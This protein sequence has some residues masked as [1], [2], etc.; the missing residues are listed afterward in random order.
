MISQGSLW[1][2][3]TPGKIAFG[4]CLIHYLLFL[5]PSLSAQSTLAQNSDFKLIRIDRDSSARRLA[6]EYLGDKYEGWQVA[7]LNGR[8]AFQAGDIVAVPLKPINPAAVYAHEYRGV[9][10]LCYH[11]F[12]SGS[13]TKHQME[14]SATE[15]DKQMAYL[16]NNG[17]QVI[18][19]RKMQG[20]LAGKTSI[21][22]KT[23][24]L[25][26]DDGYRSVYEVAYPILKKYDLTA[27]LFVY[28]D[29]IGGSMALS[30]QQ[31]KEMESSGIIDIE[32]HTKTHASLSFDDSK[33]NI[34]THRTRVAEEIDGAEAA[35]SKHLG[36]TSTILAYPY[37][38]SSK[39]TIEHLKAANYTLA[40]TVKRGLNNTFA[41]PLLLRRTMIYNHHSLDSFTKFITGAQPR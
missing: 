12:S 3:S 22:S 31:I 23:V 4:L 38:N 9:P 21:S 2:N 1:R 6:S 11:Q 15:F 30:W 35:I 41:Y 29:F 17:Y 16:V 40:T 28:T 36:H 5:S 10:V 19:L 34:D 8:S 32:S 7:E 33:E 14:V 25:T 20:I 24:I 13:S 39:D 37:G 26:I 27:T 18:P